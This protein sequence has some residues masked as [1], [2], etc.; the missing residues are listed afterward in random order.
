MSRAEEESGTLFN[1]PTHVK[2]KYQDRK[3]RKKK[4]DNCKK[5]L[6]TLDISTNSKKVNTKRFTNNVSW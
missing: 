3:K 6:K 5:F 4:S 1:V 2:E